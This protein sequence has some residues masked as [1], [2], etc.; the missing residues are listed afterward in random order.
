VSAK[1][2]PGVTTGAISVETIHSQCS[3][4]LTL[5]DATDNADPFWWSCAMSALKTEA[6]TGRV[7]AADDLQEIYGLADP[8]HPNRW[9]AL[10]NVAAHED[11]IEHVGYRK[12]RRPSRA[13]GVLRTWRGVVR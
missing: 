9:G 6:R 3:G 12:S 5:S 1:E 13:S 8:D 10:F 4:Q 7:F 2:S 11:L